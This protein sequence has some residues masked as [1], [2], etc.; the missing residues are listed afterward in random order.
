MPSMCGCCVRTA[1]RDSAGYFVY[2]WSVLYDV[3]YVYFCFFFFSSRRRHTRFDCDWSSDVCSS[4]LIRR[5]AQDA[6]GKDALVRRGVVCLCSSIAFVHW[7]SL[8]SNPV[9]KRLAARPLGLQDQIRHPGPPAMQLAGKP[10]ERVVIVR[11]P[12]R[13]NL[14]QK[15]IQDALGHLIFQALDPRRKGFHPD[16]AQVHTAA[17]VKSAQR[18]IWKIPL[19]DVEAKALVDH[20]RLVAPFL[21]SLHGVTFIKEDRLTPVGVASP[22]VE[23][24]HSCKVMKILYF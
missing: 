17:R 11:V 16:Y 19:P 14:P 7:R 6:V 15:T 4:D 21:R 23:D 1:G 13:R 8:G 22:F 9:R 12:F 20:P 2:G 5:I 18:G 10:R 24:Q 3:L